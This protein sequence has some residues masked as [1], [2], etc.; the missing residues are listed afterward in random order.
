[1][2]LVKCG[3][4]TNYPGLPIK[5]PQ[6][7]LSH[8]R[9][10]ATSRPKTR[11]HPMR[12]DKLLRHGQRGSALVVTL[13]VFAI[14][15]ALIVPMYS[16]YTLFLRRHANTFN[17]EQAY[18]YLRGGEELAALLLREDLL[19][20]QREGVVRDDFSELWA[21]QVP[22]YALDEGGWLTGRLE[23]LSGR[24][25]INSLAGQA[26]DNQRFS[27]QQEQFI[28]L[29]QTLEEPQV[30]EQDAIL[31]TESVVDWLDADSQPRNF[32][33]EDDYYYDVTPSYRAANRAMISVSELQAVA[34]VT[35]EIYLAIEPLLTV[36]TADLKI[37]VNTAPLQVLRTLNATN[38][39]RPLSPQEGETLLEL[40]GEEGFENPAA[41][42]ESSVF[43]GRDLSQELRDSLVESSTYFLFIAQ[44]DVAD[45]I[46]HLYSVLH[47]Q[48]DR[49]QALVRASGSL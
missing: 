39:Y 48:Q 23:D 42:L 46:S 29:L 17:A 8:P 2:V 3:G 32:G 12:R 44:V 16:E 13:L 38:D 30:E 6:G 7:E 19:E 40:R 25:N 37:N 9:V 49:V 1:M 15:M 11:V 43:E 24:F 36:W 45:R 10:P 22:P 5:P 41:M 18:A 27:A 31:I 33:A 47:R 21:Q 14:G 20:D 34:Y 35:P 28:R 4:Y 26:P